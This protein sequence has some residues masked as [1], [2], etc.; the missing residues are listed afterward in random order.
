MGAGGGGLMDSKTVHIGNLPPGA[1]PEVVRQLFSHFGAIVDVRFGGNA[2]YA[3]VD[4]VEP[5]SAAAA[6]GM[7]QYD[8]WGFRLRVEAASSCR[9]AGGAGGGG[10]MPPLAAAFG[11][12]PQGY[13]PA[14]VYQQP[15]VP[16]SSYGA[17]PP[18]PPPGAPDGGYGG[19]GGG[20][21]Q[22]GQKRA[23]VGE[24]GG[25][26]PT[27]VAE[28]DEALLSLQA[29]Q[30]ELAKQVASL[31]QKREALQAAQ[32]AAHQQ[33]QQHEQQH[34]DQADA[35]AADEAA[36]P[37]GEAEAAAEPTAEADEPPGTTAD[38]EAA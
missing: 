27:S 38:D 32:E 30:D 26:E 13:A 6:M 19:G 16:V 3:F 11:V 12:A 31:E 8:L 17:P 7:N 29:Q 14:P 9:T 15:Y 35:P 5:A 21:E 20:F 23:R 4:Y 33:L 24:P 18:G 28:I 25:P 36:E 10:G 37:T 2:K 1:T 22:V 34:G